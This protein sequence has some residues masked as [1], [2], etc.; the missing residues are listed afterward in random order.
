[1]IVEKEVKKLEDEMKALKATFE[2]MALQM[3]VF[4]NSVNFTTSAN[5]MHIDYSG[6]STYDFDGNERVVVTLSTNSGVNT[7]ATLE[8]EMDGF[9]SDFKVKRVP[10]SGGARWII[11]NSPNY[12]EVSGDYQRID[13]NYTFTVQSA[14]DGTLEAKMIW[15]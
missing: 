11:Y 3:P 5:P 6:G 1:M 8:I 14:V 2:K 13:T 7:L 10:Y 9:T 12:G 4:T 15:Q